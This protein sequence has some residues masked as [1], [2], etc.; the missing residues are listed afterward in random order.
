MNTKAR[1][2][3]TLLLTGASLLAL[4]T[5]PEAQTMRAGRGP[6]AKRV[7]QPLRSVS[8]NLSTGVLSDGA[9]GPRSFEATSLFNAD[10]SGFVGVDTA[11]GMNATEW[12]DAA[13]KDGGTNAQHAGG[14]TGLLSSFRF[15]YCSSA[16]DPKS[17]GPG[18]RAVISFR[19]G[20]QVGTLANASG[21]S[22]TLV[23]AY[24][25]SGLPANTTSSSFY[26][27]FS[28]YAVDVTLDSPIVLGG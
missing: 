10:L 7:T 23:G 21:P 20:Y 19:E 17:G 12:W 22:G 1:Y 4:Q 2:G 15:A 5:L 28:C 14:A 3:G 6:L 25:L 18:G 13:D 26:R 9:T 11:A 8:L 27:G 24:T 16:L